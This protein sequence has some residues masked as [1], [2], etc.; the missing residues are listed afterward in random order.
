MKIGDQ[1]SFKLEGQDFTGFIDKAYQNSFMVT[2]K[3]DDTEILDKYHDRVVI[4]KKKLKLIK[5]APETTDTEAT[6]DEA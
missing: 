6:D 3:S 5:S 2:F 4:N 1:V